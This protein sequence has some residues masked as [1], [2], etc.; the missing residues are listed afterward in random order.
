[1]DIQIIGAWG[2][3]LGGIGGLVAAFG[4][5]ATLLYLL[6]FDAHILFRTATK[7]GPPNLAVFHA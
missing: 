7:S 1:M 2:E 3:L 4:I 5:I 6:H